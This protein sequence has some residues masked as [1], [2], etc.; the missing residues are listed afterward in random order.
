MACI[1]RY[2]TAH[3][4]LWVSDPYDFTNVCMAGEDVDAGE[5]SS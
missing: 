3:A 1:M 2:Q 4:W 5:L